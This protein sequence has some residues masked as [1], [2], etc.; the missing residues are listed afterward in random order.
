VEG[1]NSSMINLINSKNLCK[2]HKVHPP[3]TTI[4]KKKKTILLVTL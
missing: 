4:K 3:S 1:M 2:C